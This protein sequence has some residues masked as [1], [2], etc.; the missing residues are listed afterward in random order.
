MRF[1]N[2]ATALTL[3]LL[4]AL[5]ASCGETPVE[6][7]DDTTGETTTIEDTT[8]APEYLPPDVD[9]E[10]ATFTILDYDTDEYF[11]H[12]ATYSDIHAE[13]DNGDPINDAQFKRNRT[14]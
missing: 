8:A 5:L 11:W 14:A 12:A 4:M 7:P 13:E 6:K 1:I 9:Y 10:G 2:R 3:A